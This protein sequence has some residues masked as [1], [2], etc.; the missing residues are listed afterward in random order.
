LDSFKKVVIADRCAVYVNEIFASPSQFGA[1]AT[2]VGVVLFAFQIYCDFSGYSDIAIGS[3]KL[4]GYDLMQNFDRPYLS[5]SISEFWRRWHIS[6]STWFRDYL[7][8]PLGGSKKSRWRNHFNVFITFV[9][10]G[11]WHG[12]SWTYVVWGAFHG[13][14]LVLEREGSRA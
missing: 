2:A 14:I 11:L 5:R 6:L 4:M 13:A 7:Y 12:A 3:A 1:W 9:V 8:V 10:S